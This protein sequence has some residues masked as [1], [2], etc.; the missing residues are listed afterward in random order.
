MQVIWEKVRQS[1]NRLKTNRVPKQPLSPGW[2]WAAIIMII[3]S[4][5]LFMIQS[6]YFFGD[7]GIF[8][9]TVATLLLISL[10]SL[11]GGL[12]TVLLY[13][14]KKLPN[15]YLWSFFCSFFMLFICFMGPLEV[16]ALFITVF[17]LSLSLLGALIYRLKK[18]DGIRHKL[19]FALLTIWIGLISFW[20][21]NEGQPSPRGVTLK[22]LKKANHYNSYSI[23]NPN[24]NG[25]YKVQSVT[26][27]SKNSYRKEFNR[28]DSLLTKPV[29]ASPFLKK[30]SPL[31]TKTFGFGPKE[32]PLNGTVWYPKGEGPFPLVIAVHGNHLMTDYSDP[33]YKYLGEL[34]ASRGYIFVSIDENFLNVSPFND[35]F[36]FQ[37]LEK[38]NPARAI[39]LLEHLKTWKNW[40]KEEQNPFFEKVD[41]DNIALIGHSRGGEAISIAAALNPLSHYPDDAKITFNY[42]F[43]IRSLISIAG[44]D[45]QYS[46]SGKP[47][48]LQN[49]NFL[50]LHGAHDMD[51]NSFD[52]YSQFHRIHFSPDQDFMKASVYIYG[53]NHGQ[54]N[55]TW[56]RRDGVG[57]GNQFFNLEQLMPREDQEQVAKVFISSFL[58]ATLKNKKDY[59]SIF[60]DIGYAQ[61]WLPDTMYISDY[62]DSRTT[63]LASFDE[64]IDVLSTSIVGGRIQ[65]KHLTKWKEERIKLKY[66]EAL[67]SVVRL[68]WNLRKISKTASY[69]VFLPEKVMN[70]TNNSSISF[71][72]AD[73]T[74]RKNPSYQNDLI[75]LTITLEDKEGNR[76]SLPLSH[77]SKLI[78]MIEGKILKWPFTEFSP[79]KEPVFQHFDFQLQDFKRMNPAFNPLTLKQITFEFNRTEKGTVL[80]NDIGIR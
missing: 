15:L 65:G 1:I 64:D 61:K 66:G 30:W 10:I 17:I 60:K 39:L 31:R 26:Y 51:V 4:L 34:L 45:G 58:D 2:K 63:L 29:D 28:K 43:Q 50:A 9:L 69:T 78:P 70:L 42:G 79:T 53:A 23:Q 54:F 62:G 5:I 36:I 49:I 37:A 80:I 38:E 7:R 47:V 71:S 6:I 19:L 72:M 21:M 13:A 46:P 33:G 56:G 76:A 59:T 44:T 35:M 16:S 67:N 12:L 73:S 48:P 41:M 77:V 68:D 24:Q 11:I 8:D 20:T 55:Q 74:K 3:P 22:E 27:G 40:N 18:K 52:G 14:F 32:L 75:D 25:P 57:L